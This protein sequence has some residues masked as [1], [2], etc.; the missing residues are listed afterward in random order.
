MSTSTVHTASSDIIASIAEEEV[1]P[2]EIIHET[3]GRVVLILPDG[4]VYK[5][6][7]YRIYR[8]D[9]EGATWKFVT[10]MP[11]SPARQVAEASRLACRLLRQEVR[12]LTRHPDGTLIAANREGIYWGREGDEV[13]T[14]SLV[15]VGDLRLMPPM[16]LSIGAK[17]TI[18]CGEYGS[19]SDP[20]PVRIY[21]SRDSG[22]SFQIAHI[23]SPGEVL[24]IHNIRWDEDYDHYWVLAGDHGNEPGIGILSADL[25]DFKWFVKGEQ[26]FRAVD[27]F[28]F[29]DHLIFAQDTEMETNAL[30]VI[31][32]KT[33][34]TER[35]RHFDGS[36]IYACRF[37]DIY[38]ITTT[39]EPSQVNRSRSVSL[40]ISRDAKN[41]KRAYVGEKDRWNADYFQFGSIILPVGKAQN[42]TIYF[43]GQAVNAIDGITLVAKLPAD[44]DL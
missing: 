13:M 10:A 35:L 2:L 4:T 8:S 3:P 31:D 36:C 5:G 14:K 24:H 6:I 42:D 37:G 9:D 30:I 16:R 18:V 43:S 32:K 12:A 38:A 40:W 25:Q 7:N 33:G 11:L 22:R 26:R 1:I 17:D 34:E 21:A 19:P 39:V 27:F 20:R 44:A 28:D 41:W 29:G 15:Q 23:F